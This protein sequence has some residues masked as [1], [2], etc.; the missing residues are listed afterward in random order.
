MKG[1]KPLCLVTLFFTLAFSYSCGEDDCPDGSS[2]VNCESDCREDIFGIWN[3]TNI[4]PMF[5]E[6]M[7]YEFRTRTTDSFIAITLDDGSRA[8]TGEGLL[9]SDCLSMSYTVSEGG[10]IISGTISFD[11]NTL[12]DMS[13]LGCLITASK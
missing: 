5:C 12:T 8:F 7:T 13:D 10:T 3:V 9:D 1:F 2:G 4:Q 6:L 11:G